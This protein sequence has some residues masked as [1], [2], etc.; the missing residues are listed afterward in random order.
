MFSLH[1]PWRPLA[2]L[3]LA[4]PAVALACLLPLPET[5]YWLARWDMHVISN[6]LPCLGMWHVQFVHAAYSCLK[7]LFLLNLK[8]IY[9]ILLTSIDAPSASWPII[10]AGRVAWKRPGS[11]WPGWERGGITWRRS[12]R[13]WRLMLSYISL[14]RNS[15]KLAEGWAFQ[16]LRTSWKNDDMLAH[17]KWRKGFLT[18]FWKSLY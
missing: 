2:A 8:F 18:M 12:M 15:S 1:L 11:R 9:K 4:L 17:E 7:C 10:C 5:P 6:F 3:L 16:Y 14:L 13:S